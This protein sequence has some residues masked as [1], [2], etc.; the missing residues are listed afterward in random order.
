[1]MLPGRESLSGDEALTIKRI[2]RVNHAGEFAA[3]RIYSAQITLAARLYPEIVPALAEMLRH[4][5]THCAAFR[6]AMPPRNSRPC[7]VMALW[8]WGGW[9]LG[10]LT[11]LIGPQ[12]IWICTAAVEAAVHHHLDDQLH[13]L[14]R[15]DAELSAI[16]LS[17]RAEELAHL[18]HAQDRIT[19]TGA[20]SRLLHRVIT[21]ST[22]AVIWLSTW[23][24][25]TRMAR[26]LRAAT[27]TLHWA[28]AVRSPWR[29]QT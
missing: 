6:A 28:E 21:F 15:R 16:I 22:D 2:V 29:R 14:E 26:A 19:S 8:S 10:F 12:A 3:I 24:D 5:R 25:S 27:P 17:I 13:F 9:L 20:G 4:E 23:G 1:M 11:A 18:H 7:R